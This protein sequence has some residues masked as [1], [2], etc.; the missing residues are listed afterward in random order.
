MVHA[1]QIA[2]TLRGPEAGQ[3]QSEAE[4][5]ATSPTKL[6]IPFADSLKWAT[7]GEAPILRSQ[8]MNKKTA[9]A[10]SR[11]KTGV[12]FFD[13]AGKTEHIMACGDESHGDCRTDQS[14]RSSDQSSPSRRN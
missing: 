13:I 2:V 3:D 11:L 9:K 6:T 8:S 1:D 14:R 12:F 7:R 4:A 10:S 5:E